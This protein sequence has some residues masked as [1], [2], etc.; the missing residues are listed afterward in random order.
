M[1]D[2]G[3]RVSGLGFRVTPKHRRQSRPR[4]PSHP[5]PFGTSLL[6]LGT[7]QICPKPGTPPTPTPGLRPP[8]RVVQQDPQKALKPNSAF[9]PAISGLGCLATGPAQAEA[10]AGR[11]ALKL[12][13]ILM[14]IAAATVITR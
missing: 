13:M 9:T 2:L 10:E 14:A 8:A 11:A 5:A 4:V 6:G 1:Q 7:P 3:F 12:I